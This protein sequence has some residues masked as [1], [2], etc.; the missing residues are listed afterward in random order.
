[1]DG[2]GRTLGAVWWVLRV[3][4]G[5][6]MLL[7]GADKFFDRLAAW[8]MYLAPLAERLLPVSGGTFL[9]AA[10]VLEIAIGLAILSRFT[11]WGAWACA[12]WLVA[13]AVNLAAAGSFWD[14]VL[15]DLQNAAAA[16]ALARLTGL[17]A[18]DPAR[19]R[20]PLASGTLRT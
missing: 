6:G 10:G 8:S 5:L 9:R 7:A 2:S 4:L 1:M 13:I 15:R 17:R 14:L 3:A 18:S 12:A 19:V 20:H 11:R 16:Y